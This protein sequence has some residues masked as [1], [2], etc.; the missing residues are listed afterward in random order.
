MNAYEKRKLAD[1]ALAAELIGLDV[2][3]YDISP[4]GTV[5]MWCKHLD[6]YHYDKESMV[7]YCDSGSFLVTK[8][9]IGL[10][11]NWKPFPI[12]DAFI[13]RLK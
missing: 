5:Y 3:R 4:Y 8:N 9:H 13:L 6:K 7:E 10:R 11:G 1:A 12:F 2:L